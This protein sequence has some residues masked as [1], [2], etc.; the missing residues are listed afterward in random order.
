[1][2]TTDEVRQQPGSDRRMAAL[3]TAMGAKEP[4][5]SGDVVGLMQHREQQMRMDSVATQIFCAECAA[6]SQAE[7]ENVQEQPSSAQPL[8]ATW[9]TV[10]E[11][12]AGRGA[13]SPSGMADAAEG[14]S[15]CTSKEGTRLAA[16][17]RR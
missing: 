2:T 16:T 11:G 6:E 8:L 9:Q 15:G 7:Q 17:E 5:A 13:A 1:M 3:M 12:S 14:V 10:Q 4:P